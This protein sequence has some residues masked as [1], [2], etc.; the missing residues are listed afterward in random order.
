[1][2]RDLMIPAAIAGAAWATVALFA[3]LGWFDDWTGLTVW[4][5]AALVYFVPTIIAFS[6]DH[7]QRV[8]IC[9]LNLVAGWTLIGWVVALVWSLM[10]ERPQPA[11]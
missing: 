10:R 9:A 11:H 6:A 2:S 5:I 1:M 4:S 3:A 8:A 7:R